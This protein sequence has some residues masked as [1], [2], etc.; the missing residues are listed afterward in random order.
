MEPKDL[1]A[2]INVKQCEKEVA[3]QIKRVRGV[4]ISRGRIVG[5]TGM[6]IVVTNYGYCITSRTPKDLAEAEERSRKFC[7]EESI[8]Y[9]PFRD[10]TPRE[11]PAF[12]GLSVFLIE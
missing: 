6:Y 2:P 1:W 8:A 4:H 11:P 3:V 5:L 9:I 7:E 10:A 12:N